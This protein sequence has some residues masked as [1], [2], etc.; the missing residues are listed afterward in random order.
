VEVKKPL[1]LIGL[2]EINF[3]VVRRYL[4]SGAG[5]FPSLQRLLSY[6][7]VRTSCEKQYE[8]LE[9]WI[10]WPSVQTGLS[11]DEHAIFRLGDVVNSQ[12]P[13]IFEQLEERGL[14]VGAIS[15][16]N[17][18]NRLKQPAYFI[19]DPW[20]L[21]QPD[22][23]WWSRK[24]HGAIA[25]AVN[26][27]AQSRLQPVNAIYLLCGLLRFAS[28]RN[29]GLYLKLALGARK[30]PWRKALF[31]DLFLHDLH[32]SYLA[33]KKPDFSLLFLN[34]GAHIQHH[35]FLNARPLR[36]S[37]PVRNPDWYISQDADPVAEMLKVY[38][39]IVSDYLDI[40]GVEKIFAT[41]L[42]QKP[43][44]RVKFYYR[45]KDHQ[46]FLQM[47]GVAFDSVAPRMTRDFLVTFADEAEASRAEARLGRVA[48]V[49]GDRSI[50]LFGEID[51]R[52]ASLFVTL[53]YPEEIGPELEVDL[54]GR[55]W[56]LAPHV[57]FVAIK[58]GMHQEDGFAYF[59]DNVASCAPEIGTHVKALHAAVLGYFSRIDAGA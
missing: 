47:L 43:Y 20:T 46:A 28:P 14:R 19:P 3:D 6:R 54:E 56:K 53:T 22:G 37:G 13:Q 38:D 49:S 57:A 29:Y 5:D 18:A 8:L 50:P 26:D 36:G 16:M 58:N 44:D 2:N 59:S 31:L 15:P 1:V 51:N 41:G 30:A 55:R 39:R 45:L 42:S 25:Q 11:Y 7:E 4:T 27:N 9:P 34:A 52:G 40:G 24:L 32:M 21:T 12:V 35:Y 33:R 23:S 10:Q 17:A 48:V